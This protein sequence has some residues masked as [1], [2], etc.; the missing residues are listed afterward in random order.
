MKYKIISQ[1][2]RGS[3]YEIL[4][5]ILSDTGVLIVGGLQKR[6]G[7]EK[8]D[9]ETISKMMETVWLPQ[10]EEEPEEPEK[11]R[12][13]EVEDYLKEN[14]YLAENKTL[15]SLKEESSG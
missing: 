1:T 9:K 11:L 10:F 15:E 2:K 4:Y 5:D 12:K 14:G 6:V 3:Y 7:K 8:L 13:E